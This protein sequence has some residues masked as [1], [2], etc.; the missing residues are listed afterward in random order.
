MIAHSAKLAAAAALTA[1]IAACTVPA[2]S[3]STANPQGSAG[4]TTDNTSDMTT[5]E[6]TNST[7]PPQ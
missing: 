6:T 4:T 1:I 5:N 7:T 2:Q 3:G